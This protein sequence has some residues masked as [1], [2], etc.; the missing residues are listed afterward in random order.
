MFVSF[1]KI[2]L[3][4]QMN[5]REDKVTCPG[6]PNELNADGINN[7]PAGSQRLHFLHHKTVSTG[8]YLQFLAGFASLPPQVLFK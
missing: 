4:L 8:S 2:Q 7:R 6:S 5:Q 3:F 1:D